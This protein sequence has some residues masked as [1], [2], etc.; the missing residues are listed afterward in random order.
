MIK[1]VA[2]GVLDSADAPIYYKGDGFTILNLTPN[3]SD[4]TGLWVIVENEDGIPA[5]SVDVWISVYNYS[6]LRAVSHHY[7]DGNGVAHFVVGKADLFVS[8]GND[9][10]WDYRILRFTEGNNVDT[11]KLKL[12]RIGLPDTMFWL[13]VRKPVERKRDTTYKPPETSKLKHN[14]R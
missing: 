6:S 11:V 4:T 1:G 9:S 10:V 13:H 2:W 14:L 5:E 3:Y 12:E 7:T 8:A